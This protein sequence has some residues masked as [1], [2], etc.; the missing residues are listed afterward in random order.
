MNNTCLLLASV[1]TLSVSAQDTIPCPYATPVKYQWVYDSNEFFLDVTIDSTISGIVQE[2]SSWDSD[3]RFISVFPMDSMSV[4]KTYTFISDNEISF[5]YIR[6]T[7]CVTSIFTH[8][9]E[10]LNLRIIV[11][12]GLVVEGMSKDDEDYFKTRPKI[13]AY[14]HDLFEPAI[15]D[16]KY[17]FKP[18]EF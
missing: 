14:N 12:N 1:I 4:G 8:Y 3:Y 5:F 16:L 13:W 9:V 11:V 18:V 10:N 15:N 6:T 17:Q 2:L 7:Q